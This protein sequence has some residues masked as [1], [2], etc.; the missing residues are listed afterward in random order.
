MNK[1]FDVFLSHNSKDKPAVRELAEALRARGLNVWLDEW[2]LVPG[3]PWQEALE[4]IIETTRS[5]AVLVGKD[6]LGPWQDAEM[7]GVLAEF[8]ARNLPVIPV[9]LPD[10][11][12]EPKL[13]LFLRRFTW[14]DLRGG[15]TEKGLDR[16][17]WGV[18]GNRLDRSKLATVTPEMSVATARA[19]PASAKVRLAP[20]KTSWL[21]T[22]RAMLALTL[23]LLALAFWSIAELN[24]EPAM[25]ARSSAMQ[26]TA[27][28]A[29]AHQP[30]TESKTEKESEKS[31]PP[32]EATEHSD[33]AAPEVDAPDKTAQARPEPIVAEEVI[34]SIST[35]NEEEA[36]LMV[37]GLRGEYFNSP[38][39]E[40][41][42]S[43]PEQAEYVRIDKTVDFD[44]GK[45]VPAPRISS[46]YFL[47]RWSGEIYAPVTGTYQFVSNHNDGCRLSIDG[48]AVF[49]ELLLDDGYKPN[50]VR[51]VS[52]NP[53]YFGLYIAEGYTYLKGLH[54]IQLK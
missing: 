21:K 49:R 51:S 18:T 24:R 44:W 43:F 53:S 34:S 32:A 23:P 17:Q 5:S 1:S 25:K 40:Q 48:K 50:H 33:K 27:K 39:F 16:L 35:R 42:P 11:P 45:G 29:P 15:L 26:P 54:G 36:N 10:A 3:R 41:A 28:T 9:L 2:E 47:V 30:V 7:R 6:G 8:V 12:S 14:V 46:D 20:P 19:H 13:P 4:E 38:P 52:R 37:P 31:K 22:R